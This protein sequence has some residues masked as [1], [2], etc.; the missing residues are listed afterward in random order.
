FRKGDY[1]QRFG[2][3]DH[4]Q[5]VT[6]PD[7]IDELDRHL[8]SLIDSGDVDGLHLALPE[9]T[10]P[11]D[12]GGFHYSTV[13]DDEYHDLIWEDYVATLSGPPTL[14]KL[15]RDEVALYSA[16]TGLPQRRWRIYECLVAELSP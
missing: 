5:L 15:K 12:F 4:L 16:A 10:D 11:E 3:V 7:E 2:W 14:A 13:P 8:G 6:D 1:K 9:I